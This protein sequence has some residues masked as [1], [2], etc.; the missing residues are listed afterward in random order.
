MVNQ[1]ARFLQECVHFNCLKCYF[2]IQIDTLV[3]KYL[4]STSKKKTYLSIFGVWV[5]CT[6]VRICLHL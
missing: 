1:R 2:D 4:P 5:P 3:L 6:V